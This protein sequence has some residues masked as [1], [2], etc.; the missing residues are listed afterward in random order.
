MKNYHKITN[1]TI[2]KLLGWFRR[3][4]NEKDVLSNLK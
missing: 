1:L 3:W 2:L 4:K